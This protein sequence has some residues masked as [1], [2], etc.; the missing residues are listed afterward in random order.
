MTATGPTLLKLSLPLPSGKRLTL[1]E[2][3]LVMGILNVT[4]DSFSDGGRY[5]DPEAAVA[6]A[7][8]M[9]AAG[10]DLLDIGGESTRPGSR[11]VDEA[12]ERRRV[13]PV[14]ARLA[15]ELEVPL[16][17]DTYKAA[18]AEAGLAA[19]ADLV[20]DVTALRADPALG[21]V[22]ARYG[23]PVVLMHATGLP[24]TFHD[25]ALRGAPLAA[26]LEG[27]AAA[28]ARAEGAGIR[29]ER[30][31][32]DPGLGFGKTPEENLALVREV[33]Q[34]KRLGKPVVIGPSRKSFL[35]H[36]L[37][38]ADMAAREVGTA[39]AIAIA[40]FQGAEVVRVHEVATM[41]RVARVAHAIRSA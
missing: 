10:A 2:R 11:P 35:A 16:S 32:V 22:A 31:L 39:A 5:L 28:I 36:A 18:V 33:P 14:I 7:R 4:P 13:L 17:L 3:P 24:G 12:E 41:R 20:N 25:P 30:I 27:L 38:E 23:A 8:A 6:H 9:V 40:V 19:G 26:V 21:R 37:G 15:R 1:G 34:L 29:P